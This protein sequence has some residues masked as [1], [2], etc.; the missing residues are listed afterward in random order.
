M[1]TCCNYSSCRHLGEPKW[2]VGVAVVNRSTPTLQNCIQPPPPPLYG[3]CICP[4]QGLPLDIRPFSKQLR[5][6]LTFTHILF[7]TTLQ[8]SF[9]FFFFTIISHIF[10][11]NGNYAC[12]ENPTQLCFA[13]EDCNRLQ[14]EQRSEQHL[15]YRVDKQDIFNP[16]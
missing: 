3:I 7:R 4:V 15:M 11:Q 13:E 5:K 14:K 10:T 2:T 8:A 9:F 16:G 6:I 1:F 12:P